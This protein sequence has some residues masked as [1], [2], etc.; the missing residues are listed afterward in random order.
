MD[1]WKVRASWTQTKHPAGRYEINQTYNTPNPDYWNG[2][3][4][5]SMSSAIRD[6]TLRPEISSSYE[7]GTDFRF[8]GGRLNVDVAY[9][10]RLNYDLQRYGTMSSASGYSSTLV[11]YGEEHLSRGVEIAVSGDIIQHKDFTW[12]SSVNWAA[13]RYIYN[14]VDEQY[15]TK[16]PWVAP[17]KTWH[18]IAE[19]DYERDPEGNII[20]YA[21]QPKI[22]DYLTLYGTYNPDWFWGWSNKIRYKNFHLAFS[23]DGRVGGLMFNQIERYLM[24]SG[25]LIDTDNQYRYEEVVDGNKTPYVGEGVKLVSGTVDY[26]TNGNI[27]N[28]TR[29]FAP[30]D[31]PVSYEAYMYDISENYMYTRRFYH[32]KTFFKLREVSLGYSIPKSVCDYIGLQGA[33]ISVVGQNLLLWTK[34]FRF[35]DP[36]VDGENINS[37]SIRLVGFNLTLNF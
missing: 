24:N 6:E 35:S 7:L 17:G 30:N 9:Y 21:G 32:E 19:Y 1:F 2:I 16:Y 12:N 37:P 3:G 22:S 31:I 28:D 20:H 36:D 26:D 8:F 13:D 25:R 18:W 29:V 5:M 14:K 27:V 11:N 34:D 33:D 15:S 4:A 10:E 23:F